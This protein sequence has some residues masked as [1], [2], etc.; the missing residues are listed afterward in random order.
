[1]LSAQIL[2]TEPFTIKTNSPGRPYAIKLVSM[3]TRVVLD[4]SALPVKALH[5]VLNE[6][7]QQDADQ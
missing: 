2:K 6:K 4:C 1:V 3:L 7:R 5:Q